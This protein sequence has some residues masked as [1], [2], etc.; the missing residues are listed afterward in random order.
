VENVTKA[1]K[2]KDT[3]GALAAYQESLTALDGYLELV[4]LPSAKEILTP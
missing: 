2:K 1:L 4:D 3:K